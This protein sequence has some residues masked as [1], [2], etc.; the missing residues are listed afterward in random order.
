MNVSKVI[1]R[2]F[3]A[4]VALLTAQMVAGMIIHV[5][6]PPMPNIFRWLML[7]NA[8]VVLALGSAAL[9]S[10]WKGWKLW[11]ALFAVP[12]VIATVN[13]IEGIL[14]LTNVTIDWRGVTGL[15]VAAYALAAALWVPIFRSKSTNLEANEW[16]IPEHNFI[17]RLWRLAFCSAAYVFLYFL[18]GMII[19]PYVRDFYATQHIP[20]FG[21]IVSLQFFLR[22]PAFVL[23]CLVLLRMFRLPGLSGALAV[24]L[25]FTLLSGVAT[26]ILPNPIFPDAVRL[27]H[28]CEVTSSNFVFGCVVGWIWGPTQR[29]AHHATAL[30]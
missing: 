2:M 30:A 29:I 19:F 28:L 25:A 11:M 5:S 4:W 18:A 23:V 8:L 12:A 1:T 20:S 7:S 16:A 21:Q 15:T 17:Q 27:V 14:F 13:M 9:R 22:G 6:T 26:L 3:L 24:G 10:E